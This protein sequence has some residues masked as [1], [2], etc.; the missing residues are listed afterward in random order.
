MAEDYFKKHELS[1]WIFA[2]GISVIMTI[3]IG[4]GIA[5]ILL[6][7]LLAQNINHFSTMEYFALAGAL[8]VTIAL[9]TSITNILIIRGRPY[10]V[11]VNTYN[12]Y[13]QIMCYLLFAIAFEHEDKWIGMLFS[14]LPFLSLWLMST[15]KYHAFVAYHEALHKDPIGFREKLLKRINDS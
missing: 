9:T 11:K 2:I 4:G 7:F 14:V 5:V 13:F 10:G 8:G 12:V 3:L 15:K 1:L 6:T